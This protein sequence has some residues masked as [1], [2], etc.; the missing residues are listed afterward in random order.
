[1][2]TYT[3]DYCSLYY[4][5]QWLEHD[6]KYSEA[7]EDGNE[8]TK[9][10]ALKK[11]LSFYGI[12]RNL[13]TEY[14]EKKGLTRYK[15][16]LDIIDSLKAED[17]QDNIV[18]KICKVEARISQKYGNKGVLSLSTKL[19]WLK[20]K[21]PIIIYDNQARLALGTKVG[22][23][24]SYYNCWRKKFEVHSEEISNACERLYKMSKYAVDQDIGTKDYIQ[25]ISSEQ[26]FKERV[27]DIYLWRTP[28]QQ[29]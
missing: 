10:S 9:L 2:A 7:L 11:A 24:D 20:L 4:L 18:E 28:D 15:P 27:F 3:F 23:L 29:S 13:P 12:A 17:F 21:S 14:D 25:N 22:D 16:V 6:K 5:N 19:L 1:M 8:T 26:W